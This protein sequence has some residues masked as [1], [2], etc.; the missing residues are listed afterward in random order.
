LENLSG[1]RYGSEAT[2]HFV[3]DAAGAEAGNR[4]AARIDESMS[5]VGVGGE[6]A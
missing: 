2:E 5:Q 6:V 1:G 4:A 3:T